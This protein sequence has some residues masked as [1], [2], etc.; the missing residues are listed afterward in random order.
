MKDIII[1]KDIFGGRFRLRLMG[2]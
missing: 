1:V 2:L